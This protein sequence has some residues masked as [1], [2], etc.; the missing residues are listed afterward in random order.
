MCGARFRADNLESETCPHK[1]SKS[2]LK[3]G[4][5]LTEARNFN[6]MFKTFMGPL[7]DESAVGVPAPRNRAGIYVNFHNV[8]GP[9]R[10]KIPFG[11][12]RSAR[13]S[14][15]KSRPRILFSAPR[16]FEQM[17]M[18]YFVYPEE[19]EQWF[20]FWKAERMK[21]YH[22]L[23]IRPEKLR[24]TDHGPNDLCALCQSGGG[25]RI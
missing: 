15:M 5:E 11:I 4:G 12:A 10:Q 1:P 6:L 9:S 7:E 23:G 20:E 3:C 16:E 14:V 18:Q 21:Y 13:L 17:E 22:D 24:M 2:P 8:Q 19:D 25:Y